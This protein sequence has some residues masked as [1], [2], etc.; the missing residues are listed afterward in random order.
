[1]YDNKGLLSS[2]NHVTRMSLKDMSNINNHALQAEGLVLLSDKT[3]LVYQGCTGVRSCN[4]RC[5]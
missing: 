4:V 1:M 2:K 5:R 3:N